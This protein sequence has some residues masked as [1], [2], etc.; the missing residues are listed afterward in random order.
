[1]FGVELAPI[2][3]ALEIQEENL[4]EGEATRK[5]IRPAERRWM[6]DPMERAMYRGENRGG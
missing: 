6:G 5:S 4:L 3:D 1:M 2:K